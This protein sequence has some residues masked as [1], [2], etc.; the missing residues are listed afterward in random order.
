MNCTG[1]IKKG[2]I[3]VLNRRNE[4]RVITRKWTYNRNQYENGI[5]RKKGV[6]QDRKA[7]KIERAVRQNCVNIFGKTLGISPRKKALEK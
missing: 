7:Q 4:I 2:V 6:K 1:P 3:K 5:E